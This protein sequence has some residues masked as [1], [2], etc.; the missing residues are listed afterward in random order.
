MSSVIWKAIPR[1]RP[2]GPSARPFP[3]RR[4]AASKSFRSSGSSGRGIPP[5][6]CPDRTPGAAASPHPA[7]VPRRPPP[8]RQEPPNPSS[9]RAAR[10]RGRRDSR[11]PPGGA[12]AVLGPHG[13][14]PAAHIG[15]VEQ[16]VV[17]ERRSCG[18]VSTATPPATARSLSRS[19]VVVER[20]T[21]RGAATCRQSKSR[22]RCR[23]RPG[24]QAATDALQLWSSS[25]AR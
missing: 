23:P 13:R 1:A 19:T 11:R 5:P 20:K 7:P 16:V 12:P 6:T 21:R 2:K 17:D 15:S 10:T 3:P 9:P 18:R 24:V 4:Q 14:P 8:G 25:S 22:P